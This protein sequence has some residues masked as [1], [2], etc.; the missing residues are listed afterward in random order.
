MV[1]EAIC[2]AVLALGMPNAETACRYMQDVVEAA[3]KYDLDPV[4]IVSLIRVES[5]WT[6][7]AVSRSK[8][9]GL[10][11][12]LA[13]YTK[14]KLTCKQLL[15]PKTSIRVGVKKLNFWIYKYGKGNIRTGLCG[16][17]AGFRCKGKNKNTI[18]YY[19]YAPKVLKYK[20]KIKRQLKKQKDFLDIHHK[21]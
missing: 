8:A 7:T 17:N 1:A 18:G 13:K 10:M 3:E 4:L 14:P 11:Q 9:C 12:V 16:Y 2:V 21:L 20:R 19:R 6:P 5:R 15:D